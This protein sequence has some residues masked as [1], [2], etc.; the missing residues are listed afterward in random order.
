MKKDG[1]AIVDHLRQTLGIKVI[2]SHGESLGGL[3]AVHLARWKHLDFLCA[4]RTFENLFRIGDLTAGKFLGV[5]FRI[6]TQWTTRVAS[7]YYETSCYKIITFDS[8]DEVIP[9]M[10]SLMHGT[11]TRTLQSKLRLGDEPER[12]VEKE[13]YGLFFLN[14]LIYWWNKTIYFVKLEL[15][16]GKTHKKLEE[17]HQSLPRDHFVKLFRALERIYDLY[18]PY[19]LT[20]HTL[21][22]KKHRR[23][24]SNGVLFEHSIQSKP[25][26]PAHN[27]TMMTKPLVLDEDED[28]ESN[29]RLFI[30]VQS[31]PDTNSPLAL[32]KI[33]I[34]KASR[35]SSLLLKEE[36]SNPPK[37]QENQSYMNLYDT[38]AQEDSSVTTFLEQVNNV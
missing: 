22:L 13:R 25:V 3:V 33:L 2:G 21:N 26:L 1:E 27:M 37:A 8:K 9:F 24:F 17:N 28:L 34:K 38:K 18:E 6:I 35:Q 5:F 16:A 10:G 14:N 31:K 32:G 19:C 4:D 7:D 30:S 29:R 20:N 12:P 11:T 15:F 23:I 36:K